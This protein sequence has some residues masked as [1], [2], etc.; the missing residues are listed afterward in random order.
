MNHIYKTV[1]NATLGAW[2]VAQE[3]AKARGKSSGGNAG[4]T[5]GA[6]HMRFAYTA[7]ASVLLLASGQA[8]ALNGTQGGNTTTG[9]PACFFDTS[10]NSVVCGNVSTQA[11][12]SSAV[13]IGLAAQATGNFNVAI[14]RNAMNGATSTGSH[15]NVA[16]GDGALQGASS[17]DNNSAIGT[18]AG[19]QIN[20][21]NNVMFGAYANSPTAQADAGLGSAGITAD[22]TVAVGNRAV[23]S[24]NNAI[25]VGNRTHA[26]GMSSVAVG[27]S[28]RATQGYAIA[29]GYAAQ[30]AGISSIAIGGAQNLPNQTLAT[31]NFATAI[32]MGANA[33]AEGA[34]AIGR[35]ANHDP[36]VNAPNPNDTTSAMRAKPTGVNS[37]ALGTDTNAQGAN[38]IAIGNSSNAYDLSTVSVGNRSGAVGVDYANRAS[39]SRDDRT[40]KGRTHVEGLREITNIGN[41]AGEN[42]INN[43]QGVN[44]GSGAGIGYNSTWGGGV[45]VGHQSGAVDRTTSA[46]VETQMLNFSATSRGAQSGVIVTGNNNT[47]VGS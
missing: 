33:G 6:A 46:A 35:N 32:G 16:I 25:A 23:A 17:T 40:Q 7:V 2:T 19:G 22:F 26:T 21:K 9:A 39:T 45:S 41:Q 43:Q 11:T 20:G 34:I 5:R 31:H 3:T 14:G 24:Q 42:T 44:I 28:A 10:T 38:A 47:A 29:Q 37:V 4:A 30:A 15:S 36:N 12:A 18:S 27:P 1:W 8:V 13:A